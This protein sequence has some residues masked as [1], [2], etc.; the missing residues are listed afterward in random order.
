[1]YQKIIC[2]Y[3]KFYRSLAKC[4]LF[5]LLISC[6][7]FVSCLNQFIINLFQNKIQKQKLSNIH[8]TL[9]EE[10]EELYF[11]SITRL[12]NIYMYVF[13]YKYCINKQDKVVI[14][15]RE[16]KSKESERKG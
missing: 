6:I 4:E 3:N 10:K 13:I 1:M 11:I 12:I 15:S 16:I 2:S 5:L 14:E 8:H 7:L 9:D